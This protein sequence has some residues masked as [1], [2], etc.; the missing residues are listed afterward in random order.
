MSTHHDIVPE[1]RTPISPQPHGEEKAPHRQGRGAKWTGW[2]LVAAGL[3]LIVVPIALGMG[4]VQDELDLP[5]GNPI[6][7]PGQAEV[8]LETGQHGIWIDV[9]LEGGEGTIDV[10]D[11]SGTAIEWTL[12]DSEFTYTLEFD[13]AT[14]ELIATFD[15]AAEGPHAVVV[16]S[17]LTQSDGLIVGPDHTVVADTASGVLLPMGV[18]IV[19]LVGGIVV[20]VVA[21]K[22]AKENTVAPSDQ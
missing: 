14:Y 2:I 8:S 19:L 3:A 15:S 22:R 17:D 4:N 21:R 1:T 9:R 13:A 7:V 20:L 10:L 5:D 16:E 18:G 11:P 6:D 12:R